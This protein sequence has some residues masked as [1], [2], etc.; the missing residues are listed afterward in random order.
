[1]KEKIITINDYDDH[2]SFTK[3]LIVVHPLTC[4]RLREKETK[5]SK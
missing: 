5:G 2:K 4:K 3:H 1:M